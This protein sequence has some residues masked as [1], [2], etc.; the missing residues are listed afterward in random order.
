MICQAQRGDVEAFSVLVTRHEKQVFR[1]VLS[2][3][4]NVED[5]RDLTQEVFLRAYLRL[6]SYS[7]EASFGRWLQRIATNVCIDRAR[8]KRITTVPW[9][10][11]S[12]GEDEKAVEF[13]SADPGPESV[14][15]QKESLGEIVAA[16]EKLPPHYREAF[17]MKNLS[18]RSYEEIA[19]FLGCPEGTV[20]SRVSRAHGLLRKHL[21]SLA[22]RN[23]VHLPSNMLGREMAAAWG[24]GD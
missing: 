13:P 3:V 6:G 2:M 9:P 24:P 8:R 15:E 12:D 4:R 23:T 10:E 18:D 16:T 19:G 11:W 20:K 1:R 22:P 14:V 21:A 7:G 5:A 17:L